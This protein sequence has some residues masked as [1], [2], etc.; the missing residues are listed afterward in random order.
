MRLVLDTNVVVSA[1][2]WRGTP[3]RLLS[4]LRTATDARLF[5]SAA[6]IE[7]LA[8]VLI[9]PVPS[10]RLGLLGLTARTVVA[11]YIAIVEMVAPPTVPAVV[12]VD[13]DDDQVIAAAVAA[14]ADAIVTG[15]RHLLALDAFAGITIIT[16]AEAMRA[17]GVAAG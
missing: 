15:D 17:L 13:P 14:R 3:F 8:E 1:L 9:R 12:A 10:G 6:L 11:D 16:P 7:E 2:L 5:A 4:A